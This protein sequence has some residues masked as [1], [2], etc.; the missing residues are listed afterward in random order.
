MKKHIV[1]PFLTIRGGNHGIV[2]D[3]WYRTNSDGTDVSLV[4]E[5]TGITGWGYNIPLTFGRQFEIDPSVI[6]SQL[7]LTFALEGQSVTIFEVRPV[8]NDPSQSS[9]LGIAKSTFVR[10][11]SVWKVFWKRADLKWHRYDPL[12]EVESVQEFFDEVESDPFACFWG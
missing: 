1:L 11:R 2:A 6:R 7:D 4:D 8:W 12:A 10:S 9:E 3:N 5:S